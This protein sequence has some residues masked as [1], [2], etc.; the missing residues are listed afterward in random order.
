MY[1]MSV[2]R[3]S[4]FGSR[5]LLLRSLCLR[6][7]TKLRY[8]ARASA[9]VIHPAVLSMASRLLERSSP[10][11]RA[12]PSTI[13]TIIKRAPRPRPRSCTPRGVD[14]GSGVWG[15]EGEREGG[16]E[17][18]RARGRRGRRGGLAERRRG[19]Y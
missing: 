9:Q 16:G 7:S 8:R 19:D 4:I 10:S 13:I 14:L 18:E 15:R 12:T 6:A 17:G 5:S 11:A 2:S 3:V 1:Q